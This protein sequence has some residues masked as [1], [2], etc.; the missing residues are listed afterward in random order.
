[1]SNQNKARRLH[2]AISI[3]F[4]V[5]FIGLAMLLVVSKQYIIDLISFN[6]YKP[7]QEVSNIIDRAGLNDNGKFLFY[8]SQPSLESTSQ[9]N[10]H[11][12]RVEQTV[13]ILGCYKDYRIYIYDVQED[14]L[15]GINEVT[16]AH[17]MLHAAYE[18][19][20]SKERDDFGR[21]A[22]VEY[23]KIKNLESFEDRMQYYNKAE[24]GQRYNELHSIIGTEI[25]SISPELEKY[26]QKYFS[27]RQKVVS[28]YENYIKVFRQ[29]ND[30]VQ[31][32]STELNDLVEEINQ[33]VAV[34][35]QNV[36]DVNQQIDDFNKRAESG[37]FSSEAA[38]YQERAL[39]INQV[40]AL[41]ATRNEINDKINNYNAI[42]QEYNSIVIKSKKLYNSIDSTLAPVPAI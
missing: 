3:I 23:D 42:L 25:A 9:F 38:F 7:T 6:Q 20:T 17:E 35:N 18:R 41:S 11:C 39:I 14:Q 33:V 19:L 2:P 36:Q 31:Q 4:S 26:Y 12:D 1:M 24:P 34:Y 5:L 15:N 8:A 10:Q 16:A 21:L 28:L 30:K 40:A 37:R 27:D 13:S 22:D 29:L 32:L